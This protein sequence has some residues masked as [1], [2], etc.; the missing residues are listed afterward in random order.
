VRV[1]KAD[2]KPVESTV[3]SSTLPKYKKEQLGTGSQINFG[4]FNIPKKTVKSDSTNSTG[5]IPETSV[6]QAQQLL[7]LKQEVLPLTK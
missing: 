1:V 7:L 4:Q 2:F 3:D 5:N 6:S